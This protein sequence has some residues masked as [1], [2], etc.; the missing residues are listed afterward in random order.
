MSAVAAK[1]SIAT[2]VVTM[3]P[4]VSADWER[5][6][7]VEDLAQIA[8]AADRLGYHHLTCSEHIALPKAEK[9]RRGTRYWDPLATL[10][11]LAARTRRIRLATNV[12]VLGY[13]HPLEIAKRYGTLDAVSGGRLILGVGVGSLEAEFHL[14]GA[15]FADR[16]ARADDALRALRSA[17]SVPEPAYHGEF[18]S[19][20][21]MVVDP[22]AVQPHVPIWVGGRTLRSL[23]RAATLADGWV[24]FNVSLRQAR[25]W[26]NRF[27]IRPGFEVVL[28]PPAPLDPIGEPQWTRAVLAEMSEHGATTIAATFVHSCLTHCLENLQSL[29]ELATS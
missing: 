8:E 1:L 17:L 21:G 20:D 11:Y 28:T 13:H 2:P 6:A 19:F 22:C 3:L 12:L 9:R 18:Y 29:A 14:V 24:P 16:G 25:E 15:P 7:T 5:H 23:R 4:G 10:G 27:E 26:L